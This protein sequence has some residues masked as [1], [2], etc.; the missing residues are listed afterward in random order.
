MFHEIANMGKR[1]VT[2][3]IIY[4]IG[5]VVF[6]HV[7]DARVCTILLNLENILSVHSTQSWKKTLHWFF[8]LFFFKGVFLS[9]HQGL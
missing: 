4:I 5:A 1:L 3:A 9:Q 6:K 7:L 8:S 2:L